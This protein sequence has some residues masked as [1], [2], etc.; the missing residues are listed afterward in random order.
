[1][2]SSQNLEAATKKTSTRSDVGSQRGKLYII[3]ATSFNDCQYITTA[4]L[5]AYVWAKR[6][7]AVP[8]LIIPELQA[9]H[10]DKEDVEKSWEE[11]D[12]RLKKRLVIEYIVQWI[13]SIGGHVVTIHRR[14]MDMEATLLQ[15]ARLA[16]FALSF[17]TPN[18]VLLCNDVDLWPVSKSFWTGHLE[19]QWANPEFVSVYN[20]DF[21]RGA[22]DAGS[23]DF[24]ALSGVGAWAKLWKASFIQY[25]TTKAVTSNQSSHQRN[26]T[27]SSPHLAKTFAEVVYA[28]LDEG[29][30]ALGPSKW[31]EHFFKKDKHGIQ[32]SWDQVLASA[33]V[34][35]NCPEKCIIF[36]NKIRLDRGAWDADIGAPWLPSPASYYTDTHLVHPLTSNAVWQLVKPLWIDMGLPLSVPHRLIEFLREFICPL[37]YRDVPNFPRMRTIATMILLGLPNVL[38]FILLRHEKVFGTRDSVSL[39]YVSLV[40]SYPLLSKHFQKSNLTTTCAS[41]NLGSKTSISCAGFCDINHDR[42]SLQCFYLSRRLGESKLIL[43]WI[44]AL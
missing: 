38:L 32:W 23:N 19:K 42:C 15:V 6:F 44:M 33:M 34:G 31:D 10:R 35:Y 21:Y 20:G 9:G 41:I 14:P 29:R 2:P 7:D 22:R 8:V 27:A 11:T 25:F 39:H 5:T 16:A 37:V 24:I 17:V 4:P 28:M 3:M 13:H 12:K 43:C 40:T 1:M 18:D 30:A 26:S 36:Y